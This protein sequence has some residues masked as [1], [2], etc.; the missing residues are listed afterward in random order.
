MPDFLKAYKITMGHEGGYSQDPD[1]A[2]GETYKG[3]S[4]RY[5]PQW[6]GWKLI[7]DVK[8]RVDFPKVLD[9]LQQLQ[10]RV[11]DF[12]KKYYWD[13]NRLDQCRSQAIAEE[14]FDTA[15]NMG[16]ARAAKFL[17]ESLNYLNRNGRVY[18]DLSID[19]NI[20]PAT[21]RALDYILDNGEEIL[22]LK[23]LNV[24]QGSFY[25]NYM[26]KNPVQE[27]YMRGWFNRVNLISKGEI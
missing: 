3:I 11:Y 22:L 27:K 13:S 26:R 19:S 20:G 23:V 16:R 8:S 25:L 10:E 1:D 2:G 6:S 15:V 4:R 9:Q 24:L 7:D 14:M 17:Q 12:Y 5:N 18:P 21:L